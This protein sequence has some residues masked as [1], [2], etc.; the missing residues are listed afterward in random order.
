[1]KINIFVKNLLFLAL[2][3]LSLFLMVIVVFKMGWPGVLIDVFFCLCFFGF[4]IAGSDFSKSTTQKIEIG[5]MYKY[6]GCN[7]KDRV[8]FMSV[9]IHE[10]VP[11]DLNPDNTFTGPLSATKTQTETIDYDQYGVYSGLL[12][13]DISPGDIVEGHIESNQLGIIKK[14]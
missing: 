14:R 12:F 5:Q 4:Y 7:E 9:H 2:V 11:I 3:F 1:M 13:E 10:N 6:Y 8:L